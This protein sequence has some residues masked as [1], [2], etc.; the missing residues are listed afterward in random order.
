MQ[1]LCKYANCASQQFGFII[2]YILYMADAT[3]YCNCGVGEDEL[4]TQ[5]VTIVI[6]LITFIISY[7]YMHG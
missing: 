2:V 5:I 6:N 3:Q 7:I 4:T 1:F